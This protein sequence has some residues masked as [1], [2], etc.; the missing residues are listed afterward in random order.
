ME[1]IR[2]THKVTYM[3]KRS[4]DHFSSYKRQRLIDDCVYVLHSRRCTHTSPLS[5]AEEIYFIFSASLNFQPNLQDFQA[6][7]A[8]DNKADTLT[9]SQMLRDSDRAQFIAAQAAEIKG[10]QKME[11]FQVLPM[12]LKP[13]TAKL[14]N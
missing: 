13:A 2:S 3:A 1:T 4:E 9:Q 14:L 6:M 7:V 12:N 10:L 5:I 11:V 8:C